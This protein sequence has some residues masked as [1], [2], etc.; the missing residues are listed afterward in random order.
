MSVG[1]IMYDQGTVKNDNL[2]CNDIEVQTIN[3]LPY[4]PNNL[5]NLTVTNLNT[6][7]INNDDYPVGKD[8]CYLYQAGTGLSLTTP[9]NSYIKFP[10]S[11]L[12]A[13]MAYDPLIG[14]VLVTKAGLYKLDLFLHTAL[15]NTVQVALFVNGLN[16]GDLFM[17]E[18]KNDGNQ[19]KTWS[20]CNSYLIQLPALCTV[21][22]KNVVFA[23]V[24][25][26]LNPV[27]QGLSCSLCI[28]RV[29]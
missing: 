15:G 19:E 5:A 28:H 4:P 3:H 20:A 21:G 27:V 12:G 8:F 13:N 23:G 6:T 9:I 14:E 25:L 1:N 16:Q 29:A 26:V 22:Y 24:N 17:C 7:T 2:F 10:S 18:S 11:V